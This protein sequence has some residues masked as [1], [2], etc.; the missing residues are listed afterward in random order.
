M[1]CPIGFNTIVMMRFTKLL[2]GVLLCSGFSLNAQD[3]IFLK[4]GSRVLAS[5]IDVGKTEITYSEYGN[6]SREVLFIAKS[7]VRTLLYENGTLINME[8][9]KAAKDESFKRNI[10]SFHL[11][12]LVVSN[13]TMSYEHILASGKM[14]IQIPF[15]FGY[16]SGPEV[17]QLKNKFYTGIYLNFYPTG[18]GRVRYVLGPA[19]RFGNANTEIHHTSWTE[20][21]TTFYTKFMINNG[22]V[23]S[24]IEAFSLSVVGSLGVVYK[25]KVSPGNDEVETTG[26]FT[27]M[28]SYRF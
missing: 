4:D 20:K 17:N 9:G 10:M 18:Q 26:A 27:F 12:D 15:A 24:P 3:F 7:D 14:G 22:L 28:L 23:I 21:T 13:F 11:A 19:L 16:G 5:I 1:A 25:D 6:P 2:L 8:T